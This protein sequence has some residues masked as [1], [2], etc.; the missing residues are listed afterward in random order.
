[1]SCFSVANF[2]FLQ[3][4]AKLALGKNEHW[5]LHSALQNFV[6]FGPNFFVTNFCSFSPLVRPDSSPNE[7]G[8]K[9]AWVQKVI[10]CFQVSIWFTS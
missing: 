5:L 2:I 3:N 4:I 10:F 9:P 8:I 1:M 6:P 7:Q